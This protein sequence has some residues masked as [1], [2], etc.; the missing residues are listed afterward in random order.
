M[1]A[2]R[3]EEIQSQPQVVKAAMG[4]ERKALKGLM[5]GMRKDPSE[6]NANQRNTMYQLQRSNLRSA[7]AWRLKQALRAVYAHA[8]HCNDAAEAETALLRWI[9][10]ARRC[11]LDPFK[12]LATTL[13]ERLPGVV[14]GMLDGRSN[15]YVEAMNGMLQKTKT[16]AS[17]FHSE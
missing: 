8:L 15:A 13:T 17:G 16:A 4:T 14:R 2:V 6:W 12:R 5:W 1:D 11:R 10:W 3:R 7:R 9:S